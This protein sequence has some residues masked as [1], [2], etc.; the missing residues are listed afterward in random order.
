MA[1]E[2]K[3][4][5]NNEHK[6]IIETLSEAEA[7]AFIKFLESEIIRHEDDIKLAKELIIQAKSWSAGL[8]DRDWRDK[9]P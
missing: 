5:F 4:E 8:K 7:R 1:E 2:I 6:V 3:L 9:L